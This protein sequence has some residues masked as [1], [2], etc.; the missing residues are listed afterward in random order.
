MHQFILSTENLDERDQFAYWREECMQRMV[1]MTPERGEHKGFV[2]SIT[3]SIS[4]A[5]V[6]MQMQT[7]DFT[8]T[9]KSQDIARVGWQG[10]ICLVRH[11]G[12]SGVLYEQSGREPQRTGKGDL[13]VFDP[14]LPLYA[15]AKTGFND[16]WLLPRALIEPH[17][18]SA[19][20]PIWL[21]LSGENGV[22]G[23]IW[24]YLG[25]LGEQMT[26]LSA[27]ELA[28]VIDNFC[29]LIA[30]GCGSAAG[31][32]RDAVRAAR[33][34]QIKRYINLHL[35][36]PELTP[37]R[38]AEVHRMSVRQLHR[39]FEPTGMSF[40]QHVVRR[41]LEECRATV[42][43]P[44]SAGRSVADIAFGWGFGSLPTFYRSFSIA[45]GVSPRELRA[46]M[47]HEREGQTRGEG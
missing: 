43:N 17:L 2:G 34:E 42:I 25:A 10:S 11:I 39:L 7:E 12:D 31:D 38:V 46:H 41:R 6:R 18:P 21:R 44:A 15:E 28:A 9:R 5:V 40:T 33:L 30:I 37:A 8:A 27:N 22:N 4:D 45:F 20:A 19:N 16:I 24:A 3:A 32:Q 26:S 29:R 47:H 23:L 14:S 35:A 1:G 13:L 36:E